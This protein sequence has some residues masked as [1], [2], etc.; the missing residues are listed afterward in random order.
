[1]NLTALNM[2]LFKL[3]LVSKL[4]LN[5][6]LRNIGLYSG[7]M[8]I[9][10]YIKHHPNCT[11]IEVS[12]AVNMSPASVALST[13]KMEKCG[14]IK[15]IIEE[16]NLRCKHLEL[17]EVGLKAVEDC[18]QIYKNCDKQMYNGFS[19]EELEIFA[20]LIDKI[21][22]NLTK[23]NDNSIDYGVVS[24]LIKEVDALDNRGKKRI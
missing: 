22:L 13:K 16:E 17:T 2:R 3:G 14:L 11:Q 21:T 10:N 6:E 1:M 18:T 8:Q 12:Q 20:E 7:Q 5:K 15:K 19:E 9:L 24:E 23:E 4:H